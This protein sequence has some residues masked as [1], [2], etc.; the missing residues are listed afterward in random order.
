MSYQAKGIIHAI[1]PTELK[2]AK[3]FKVRSIILKMSDDQDFEQFVNFE[4]LGDKTSLGDSLQKGDKAILHF[5]LR[6][7]EWNERYFNS[8]VVWKAEAADRGEI[9]PAESAPAED[10]EVPF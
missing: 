10:E 3:G 2:G 1:T 5:D 9:A 7:R 6:G 4:L 8:L